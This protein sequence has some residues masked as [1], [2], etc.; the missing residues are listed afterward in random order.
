MS[1]QTFFSA[2][3]KNKKISG[4]GVG[5]GGFGNISRGNKSTEKKTTS[6]FKVDPSCA[7]HPSPNSFLGIYVDQGS[8]MRVDRLKV[9]GTK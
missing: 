5:G 4:F 9:G 8:N 3:P 1:N 6:F 2:H 7:G